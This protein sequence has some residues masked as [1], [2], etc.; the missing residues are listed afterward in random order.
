MVSVL[1]IA[2]FIT[3]GVINTFSDR[4][5]NTTAVNSSE[6]AVQAFGEVKD[7]TSRFDYVVFFAFI[8]LAIGLLITGWLVGGHPLFMVVYFIV[9]VLGVVMSAILSNVWESVSQASVF[10]GDVVAF[11]LTNYLMMNLPVFGAVL[12]GLGMIVMFAKPFF[13]GGDSY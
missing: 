1:A 5:V 8:A 10:L 2:F 6:A 7:L 9:V 3:Y 11:P 12:G 4:V 13:M